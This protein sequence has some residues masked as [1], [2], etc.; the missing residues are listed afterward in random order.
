MQGQISNARVHGRGQGG[1]NPYV[2]IATKYAGIIAPITSEFGLRSSKAPVAKSLSWMNSASNG[3][4][5]YYVR[6]KVPKLIPMSRKNISTT[7]AGQ[8]DHCE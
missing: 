5:D 4:R 1:D 6:K 8:H 3:L 7:C 2:S